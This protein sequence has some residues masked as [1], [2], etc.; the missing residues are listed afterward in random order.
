MSDSSSKQVSIMDWLKVLIP[1]YSGYLKLEHRRE[2]DRRTRQYISERISD[3]KK[4][5]HEHLK[6]YLDHAELDAIA[7][8][9]KLRSGLEMLQQQVDSQID[10]YS[11]WFTDETAKG[12]V[13]DRLSELDASTVSDIDRIAKYLADPTVPTTEKLNVDIPKA[14]EICRELRDKLERR[15]KLLRGENENY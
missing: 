11:T 6:V 10:T 15:A 12:S 14:L 8:G 9:D 3:C 13:L 5:L 7:S 1:G 4:L 2:N